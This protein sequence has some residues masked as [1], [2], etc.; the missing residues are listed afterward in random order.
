[1]LFWIL[2][3]VLT[4]AVIALVLRPRRSGPE[5]AAQSAEAGVA[6]YRDQLAEI[7]RDQ[8]RG[9]LTSQE[10]EAARAEIARRLIRSAGA[11]PVE[12]RPKG[13]P[14]FA[15]RL[16]TAVAAAIPLLAVATY[17]LVGSPG[18]PGRPHADRAA[19]PPQ[20]ASV[21]ELVARVEARLRAEPEEGQGWDVIA[22]VYLRQQ[23]FQDAAQAFARAL[24]I[25]GESPKR[26]A[27]LA[28]SLVLVNNG[29]VVEEARLAYERLA[30]LE[31][32]RPE[33]RFWLAVAK[34]QDG[35]LPEAL[36]D[37]DALL[38][39]APPDAVWRPTVKERRDLVSRR[40]AGGG[41]VRGPTAEQV[42]AAGR[43]SAGEQVQMISQMVA[44]LAA[45]LKADGRDI[46]GWQRLV[47]AYTVLGET[48]K[49]RGALADARRAL[50]GDTG[51]LATLES[52]AKSLGIG[53]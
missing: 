50:A 35:R 52:L 33:P 49:A 31:P 51:A 41:E 42:Q 40:I 38:A 2:C 11:S 16:L 47:R 21:D 29:I 12:S 15:D 53:S 45:R 43:L 27:G 14:D 19:L 24:R 10:A 8:E 18:L 6:V 44:G 30:R 28:E 39:A 3:A 7:A 25:L 22:P 9:F 26:L 4:A 46:E 37:Y 20:Q 34:E 13:T 23:R 5:A 36:A 32:E 1:M 48:D 17:V